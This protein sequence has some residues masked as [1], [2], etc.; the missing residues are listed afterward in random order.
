MSSLRRLIL[1]AD[2]FGACP[3][4]NLA[5]EKV[6]KTGI[7]GGVSVLANGNCWE[8]AVAFLRDNPQLSAGVHL[9]VVEGRPVSAAPQVRILTG[10]DGSFLGIDGLLRRWLLRPMAATCAVEIEWRAQIERL[11]RA[12][13]WLRHADSHQ[14]SHAF[15][16]GYRCAVKLCRQY[17]IPGI[18]HPQEASSRPFR[19]TGALALKSSLAVSRALAGRAG[20]SHNDHFLGFKRAGGYGIPELLEDLESIPTGLTEIGLH[21]SQCFAG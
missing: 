1:N 5:V 12:G 18:R 17:G 2:D 8:P 9:N 6:A 14:H 4:V 20:L 21:P 19:R 3:E 15:P 11:M 13:V 16:L 10:A 7:L